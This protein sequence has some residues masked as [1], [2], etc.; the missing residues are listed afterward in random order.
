M[1]VVVLLEGVDLLNQG[2]DSHFLLLSHLVDLVVS[3]HQYSVF[4]VYMDADVPM[5][6]FSSW[7]R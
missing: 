2:L 1:L 7:L 4:D 6:V 3:L 5:A